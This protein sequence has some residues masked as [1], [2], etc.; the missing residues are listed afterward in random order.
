MSSGLCTTACFLLSAHLRTSVGCYRGHYQHA[1]GAILI[2]HRLVVPLVEWQCSA[3]QI[4]LI[5][6]CRARNKA[7]RSSGPLGMKPRWSH[8]RDPRVAFPRWV[9]VGIIR[10]ITDVES[11]DKCR[12]WKIPVHTLYPLI[13]ARAA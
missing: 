9:V 11:C 1:T 2:N 3:D 12:F 5:A 7:C 8:G 13:T 4:N 6:S 10:V